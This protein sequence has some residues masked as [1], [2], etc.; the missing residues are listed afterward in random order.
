MGLEKRENRLVEFRSPRQ[1]ETRRSVRARWL[2]LCKIPAIACVFLALACATGSRKGNLGI[3]RVAK[4]RPAFS[5]VL[6]QTGVELIAVGSGNIVWVTVINHTE[7]TILVGPKM[8]ALIDGRTKHIVNPRDVTIRFPIR[9]LRH[10]EGASGA[11]VFRKLR[12]VEGKRLVFNSP[13]AGAHMTIIRPRE[14]AAFSSQA[15]PRR[16]NRRRPLYP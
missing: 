5:T 7:K 3:P 1:A 6:P 14:Q 13:E 4:P 16:G 2:R 12:S 9:E 8:F 15:G 11:F 10:E